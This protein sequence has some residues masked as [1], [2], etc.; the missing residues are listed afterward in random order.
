MS[1][2]AKNSTAVRDICVL[3]CVFAIWELTAW[4]TKRRLLRAHPK[5]KGVPLARPLRL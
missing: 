5:K 4:C 2:H 3:L 1:Q